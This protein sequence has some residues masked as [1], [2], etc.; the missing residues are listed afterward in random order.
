MFSQREGR[1]RGGV[2]GVK[3]GGMQG[4]QPILKT[5]RI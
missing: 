4:G 1:R 2:G 5:A 3:E